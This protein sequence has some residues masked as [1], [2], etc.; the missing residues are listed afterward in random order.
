MEPLILEP[1]VFRDERGHL[2]EA[3]R[4]NRF[5]EAVGVEVDFVQENHTH[6]VRGV[7]RGLHYQLPP[8]EQGKLISVV[9]GEIFDVAVDV[10]RSSRG[11]GSG[12]GVID[13]ARGTGSASG[14]R[15]GSPTGSSC[16]AT[17][18]T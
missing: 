11:S 7:L 5:A 16:S 14:S 13:S 4:K 1:Q 17:P 6:S 12:G 3:Y 10:R 9:A 2:Y 15:R 8:M 18:P